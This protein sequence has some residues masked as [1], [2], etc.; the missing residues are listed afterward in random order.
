MSQRDA[1]SDL[2]PES[3]SLISPLNAPDAT[4]EARGIEEL[5]LRM[6]GPASWTTSQGDDVDTVLAQLD[7]VDMQDSDPDTTDQF[8]QDP[9]DPENDLDEQ[10]ELE[11]KMDELFHELQLRMKEKGSAESLL[12]VYR[13]RDIGNEGN[14]EPRNQAE[15]KLQAIIQRIEEINLQMDYYKQQ[16]FDSP[17]AIVP[18]QIVKEQQPAFTA[19]TGRSHSNSFSTSDYADNED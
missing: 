11:A 5:E 15:R 16:A 8:D 10:D 14:N 6:D 2:V 3:S 17:F 1:S 13:S 12:E 19:P 18:D 9:D 4:A 7:D